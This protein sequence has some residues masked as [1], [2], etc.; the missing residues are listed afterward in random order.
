MLDCG[1]LV[2]NRHVTSSAVAQ[3]CMF[4]IIKGEGRRRHCQG[5]ALVDQTADEKKK[6]RQAV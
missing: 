6:K 4:I 1:R 5:A 3:S 2:H